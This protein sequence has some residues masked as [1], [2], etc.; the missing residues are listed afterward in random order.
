MASLLGNGDPELV[1]VVRRRLRAEGIQ[2][3][4]GV[5][6]TGVEHRGNRIVVA[7]GGRSFEGSH[8]LIAA[9]RTPNLDDLGLD[10]AHIDHSA[11]GIG[12]DARMRT[13]NRRVY[14]IDIGRAHD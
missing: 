2:I 11:T 4:E 7:A 1:D 13:S 5:S 9:G 3:H 6:L 14:A 8:L 10:A 12:V